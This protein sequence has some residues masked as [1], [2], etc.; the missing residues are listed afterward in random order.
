MESL[1]G[2]TKSIMDVP[3]LINKALEVEKTF[4]IE[5]AKEQKAN[6]LKQL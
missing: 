2:Q 6:A 3:G 5:Q 1:Q 4:L